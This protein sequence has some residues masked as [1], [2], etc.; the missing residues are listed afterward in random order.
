MDRPRRLVVALSAA[1]A[2]ALGA[3]P[4]AAHEPQYTASFDRDRCTFTTVGGNPFLPLWPGHRLLLEGEEE[5]DGETVEI[6]AEITVL[7][8]TE[9]VDGVLTRVLEERESED[10]ELVEVSRNFLAVC[11]ET[12]DVWYFGE[13]V[14]DYEDGEVVG[15]GGAWRAGVGGARAGVLMLG[16]PTGGARHYQEVAPG[17]ALDRAEVVGVGGS[18]TV[19]AGTFTGVLRVL[20]SNAL[21]P[22]GGG[23]LKVYAPGVGLIVDEALELVEVERAPCDPSAG[24]LCLAD[25]RVRVSVRFLAGGGATPGVATA[26]GDQGGGFWFGEPDALEVAVRLLGDCDGGAPAFGFAATL[27]GDTPVTLV[28]RDDTTGAVHGYRLPAADGAR[29]LVDPGAFACP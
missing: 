4:A 19:P 10:G 23:D 11:R 7:P 29:T 24:S 21:D 6:A 12:G 8:D 27:L 18:A 22:D 26:H 5:S 20:D 28:V 16:T 2:L 1:L 14:D 15:H 17:V 9:L 25:G 13:D 3:G